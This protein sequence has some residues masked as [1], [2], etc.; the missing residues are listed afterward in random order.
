MVGSYDTIDG[1]DPD[2]IGGRGAKLPEGPLG[3][4]PPIA[5]IIPPGGPTPGGPPLRPPFMG[6]S[7]V[8]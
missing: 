1:S 5:P 8:F 2:D 7:G 6:G 4:G 3:E